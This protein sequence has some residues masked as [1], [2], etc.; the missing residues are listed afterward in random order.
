M[1]RTNQLF[2]SN[3]AAEVW[4]WLV[5]VTRSL[6][7]RDSQKVRVGKIEEVQVCGIS[8]R[9]VQDRLAG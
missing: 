7:R 5:M 1:G 2:T 8:D 6:R 3:P 4:M 9:L